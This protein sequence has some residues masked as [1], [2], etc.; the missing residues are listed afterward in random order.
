[1]KRASRDG[2]AA[3]DDARA[4][5]GRFCALPV[6]HAYT[7]MTLWAAHAWALDAFDSTPRLAFLSPEPGSGKTRALEILTLLVPRPMH[8]VN[9]TPAALFRSVADPAARR[10]I[11]FDEIDT[12]FGPKA[13]E[14][15]ELRGLLNA[16]HR[17]SGVAYR[18]VGEGTRQEVAAF[19]AY[20]GVALAGLGQLPD[21]ILTRSVVIRMRRRA[22]H[23]HVEPFRARIHEPEGQKIGQQLGDW[24]S[25]AAEAMTGAWP[26]M[27]PGVTD[28]PADVWE[29]LLTVA[30]AAGGDWPQRA[31]E[32]C[33][34]LVRDNADRGIS[35]GIR[36]LADLRDVFGG[37]TAMST[38]GILPRLC[39]LDDA[40]WADLKGQPLD[41]RGLSRLLA[42]YDIA[43]VKVK[44][45]GRALMGYRADQLADAWARYL[46]PPDSDDPRTTTEAPPVA[47]GQAKPHSV[48]TEAKGRQVDALA[49][50]ESVPG[51]PGACGACG[52]L[53]LWHGDHGRYRNR[54]CRRCPCTAYTDADASPAGSGGSG[55]PRK[56]RNPE[57]PPLPAWVP[58][59][60]EVPDLRQRDQPTPPGAQPPTHP[61]GVT[62]KRRHPKWKPSTERW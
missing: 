34:W 29:P 13:K 47:Q 57:Y 21:T 49:R 12:I 25:H 54:P 50:G 6:E 17:R 48:M 2:A 31:R 4:F 9:A 44:I 60:P 18:C 38:A 24:A 36:L 20:A 59:V 19:P 61:P 56:E 42:P 26:D 40:P 10:T 62:S 16:G 32:A 51:G 22:P 28:R 8:A 53:T 33:A 11:L 30:D 46:P 15:E 5:I 35:L 39:D 58:E 43:P 7:A 27:P 14:H 45:G 3:L 41:A 55:T 1:V 23:E 37:R 52:H